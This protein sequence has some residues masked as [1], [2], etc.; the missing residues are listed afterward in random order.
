MKLVKWTPIRS[1][2]NM[3]DDLDTI[4][5]NVFSHNNDSFVNN[6]NPSIDIIE[7]NDK[8]IILE[9]FQV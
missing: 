2:L 8:F 3:I 9:I 6:F 4:F 5:S 7:E 1:S